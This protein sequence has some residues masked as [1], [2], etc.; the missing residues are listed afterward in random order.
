VLEEERDN[1]LICERRMNA[2]GSKRSLNVNLPALWLRL[3]N[4]TRE[5]H[6]V[7]ITATRGQP[8]LTL[9]FIKVN[10]V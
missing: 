4:I 5:T 10:D 9:R 3:F 7:R 8:E 2:V 1:S 6:V